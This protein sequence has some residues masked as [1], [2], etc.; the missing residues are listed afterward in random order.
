M[1]NVLLRR[2]STHRLLKTAVAENENALQM[3]RSSAPR[4]LL[5]SGVVALTSRHFCL[6]ASYVSYAILGKKTSLPGL[7]IPGPRATQ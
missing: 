7:T 4:V 2:A 5:R 6:H 3:V 1:L